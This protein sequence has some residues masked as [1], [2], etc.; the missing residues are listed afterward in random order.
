MR[1]EPTETLD[2]LLQASA[3]APGSWH[4]ILDG[5][6]NLLHVG[7]FQVFE[8]VASDGQGERVTLV[9]SRGEGSDPLLILCPVTLPPLDPVY[10][11][12]T[13]RRDPDGGPLDGPLAGSGLEALAAALAAATAL[14]SE[15]LSRPVCVVATLGEGGSSSGLREILEHPEMKPSAAVVVAPTDLQPIGAHPGRITLE[16]QVQRAMTHRRMPPTRG[17]TRLGIRGAAEESALDRIAIVL[18]QLS[19]GGEVHPL[20]LAAGDRADL[21]PLHGEMV[22]A[23]S[24]ETLPDLPPWVTIAPVEDGVSLPF[25]LDDVLEV[26]WRLAASLEPSPIPGRIRTGRDQVLGC[27]TWPLGAGLNP[28]EEVRHRLLQVRAIH[29]E[30]G[31]SLSVRARVRESTA[32]WSASVEHGPVLRGMLEAAGLTLDGAVS[33]PVVTEADLLQSNDCPAIVWGP[34]SGPRAPASE[35]D[36]FAFSRQLVSV[37]KRH[38][39][40]ET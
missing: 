6:V 19:R 24:Y 35:E 22:V 40:R 18:R 37:I 20:W 8:Q 5:L 10:P 21:V 28:H 39:A 25:P 3:T 29:Q 15:A 4:P 27:L 34:G 38:C 31:P 12:E 1:L 26:W 17:L 14:D 36:C 16:L 2:R 9:A 13:T 7:R 11:V 32:P 33:A 23:T 30:L